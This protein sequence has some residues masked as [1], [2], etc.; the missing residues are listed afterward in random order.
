MLLALFY[1]NYKKIVELVLIGDN[2]K[3]TENTIIQRKY[4]K[5][6]FLLQ[7]LMSAKMREQYIFFGICQKHIK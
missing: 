6:V 5:A 1:I 2:T 4:K 7:M 3:N